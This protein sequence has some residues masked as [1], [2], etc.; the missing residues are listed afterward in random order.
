MLLTHDF[1]KHPWKGEVTSLRNI[2][3]QNYTDT[4]SFQDEEVLVMWLVP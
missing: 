3:N 4:L 1:A 2:T